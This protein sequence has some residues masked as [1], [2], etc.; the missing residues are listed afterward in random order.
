[1]DYDVPR[2]YHCFPGYIRVFIAQT[3]RY[4]LGCLTNDFKT[5]YYGVICLLITNKLLE[6]YTGYETLGSFDI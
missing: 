6:G 5:S 4:V 2:T 1:M 3:S